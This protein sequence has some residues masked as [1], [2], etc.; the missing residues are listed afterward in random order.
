MSDTPRTDALFAQFGPVPHPAVMAY[1]SL[2]RELERELSKEDGAHTTTITQRDGAEDAADN[3]ASMILGEEID[4]PD[5]AAKWDEALVRAHEERFAAQWYPVAMMLPDT[6]KHV[7][8]AWV[9]SKGSD[10]TMRTG[11][12]GENG[13]FRPSGSDTWKTQPTHWREMPELNVD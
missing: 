13:L 9:R 4:W 1:N 11:Y 2:A 3:L 10:H 6:G 7:L 5:H 8:C 12:V